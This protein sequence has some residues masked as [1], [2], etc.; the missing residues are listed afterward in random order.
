MRKMLAIM[1]TFALLGAPAEAATDRST[2]SF[3]ENSIIN[4]VCSS[5]VQRGVGAYQEC[6][7]RQ[8]A[9]LQQHPTPD[10]TSLSPSRNYAVENYCNY[11]QRTGIGPYND[12]IAR[13]IAAPPRQADKAP[14]DDLTPNFAKV[15]TEDRASEKPVVTPVVAAATLPAPGAA[16]PQ[17]PDNIEHK[18]LP[19]KELFKKLERSV[20]VVLASPSLAEAKVRNIVQGSAIAV[21]EDLLLT[22]CHVVKDRPVI[23]LIQ[24]GK[25]A[26]ATLVAAD[27]ASDRCV[28]KAEGITLTP[29]SG[30]RTVD[31]LAVGER[32]FAIGAPLSLELTLSEGLISGI[33]REVNP[34]AVQTSAP[35]SHGSSGGGL[36]DERGNLVGITTLIYTNGQNVN[37]AIAA[38]E[39][40]N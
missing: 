34:V 31:S 29:I 10:R 20:F 37:F 19:P 21:S 7:A 33:R 8:V 9:A 23:K 12:C 27:N 22:N 40:W 2:L 18:A 26:D 24:E 14:G 25:R 30:V 39:Y 3:T 5:A 11:L 28:I 36:F 1:G 4:T 32:V 13:M 17:R 16:L 15:F 38:A 6:V 35:I